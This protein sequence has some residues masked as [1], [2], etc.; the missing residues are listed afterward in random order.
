MTLLRSILATIIFEFKRSMSAQRV[1]LA[2]VLSLFP[3]TMLFFTSVSG[4]ELPIT[5]LLILILVGMVSILA[6]LLWA[7]PNVYSELEGKSWI[8]LASRPRGRIA[9][10]L[11]KYFS[12]VIF[13]FGICVIA[14]TFCLVIKT[15][16]PPMTLTNPLP[17]WIGLNAIAFISCM[18]YSAVFSVIGT[19]FQKR[20]MVL[21]AA[22]IV[23]SEAI[24]ANVPAIISR[25]TCRYHLQGLAFEWLG[26]L[27]PFSTSEEY[28]LFFGDHSTTFHLV[29]LGVGVVVLLVIGCVAVMTRQYVTAEET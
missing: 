26:W 17:D 19:L 25:F 15:Y 27:H 18:V 24:I 10:F 3:P 9:L 12:S 6:Q 20:A 28:K 5:D 13:S 4:S 8:F 7:T 22:Y 1:L 29:C 23:L 14:I 16:V 11:G 21:G 2:A